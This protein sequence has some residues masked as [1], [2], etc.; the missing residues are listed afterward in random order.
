MKIEKVYRKDLKAWRWKIDITI[1]K[2]RFR[3]ADF[4][5]QREALAACRKK[6][7]VGSLPRHLGT[8]PNSIRVGSGFN[9]T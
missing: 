5:T 7:L 8:N 6:R 9:S 1:N 2:E 4:T 3:R